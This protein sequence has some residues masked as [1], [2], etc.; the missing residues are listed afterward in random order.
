MDSVLD[1]LLSVLLIIA[2]IFF[3]CYFIF[4]IVLVVKKKRELQRIQKMF[5][6]NAQKAHREDALAKKAMDP[7]LYAAANQF[8]LK[9]VPKKDRHGEDEVI[10]T[11]NPLYQPH[12]AISNSGAA[13]AVLFYMNKLLLRQLQKQKKT[14]EKKPE[15]D[16]ELESNRNTSMIPL[17]DGNNSDSDEGEVVFKHAFRPGQSRVRN[18]NFND[19]AASKGMFKTEEIDDKHIKAVDEAKNDESS[20][21]E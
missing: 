12:M 7:D 14:E 6:E 5:E 19:A 21:D 16:P 10:K 4:Q 8:D 2:T 9:I 3:V 15:V 20:E 1:V 13:H 18:P 11:K 17:E